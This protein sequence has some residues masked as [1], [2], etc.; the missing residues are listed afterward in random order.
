[1]KGF[2]TFLFYFL[3]CTW[4]IVMT[5]IGA[6]AVLVLLITGHKIEKF[7]NRLYIKVGKRWGGVSLGCFFLT[8]SY[9]TLHIKQHESGHGIQNI[10]LGPFMPFVVCFPSAIR[11]WVMEMR[12]YRTKW[13]FV[14]ALI[15]IC[16]MI[17]TVL[18][19]LGIIC[20][21]LTCTILGSIVGIYTLFMIIWL[22][23]FEVPKYKNGNPSYDSIW[24]EGS[25]SKLGEKYFPEDI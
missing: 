12:D 23:I 8:D 22:F 14:C 16:I 7:N 5:I 6:L 25:A 1:M 10:I 17:S 4:G 24:F 20:N 18:L 21:I 15:S 9:P 3:S 2:K 11:Y 19:S 13:S